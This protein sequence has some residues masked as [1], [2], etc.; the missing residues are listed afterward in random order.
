M[1]DPFLFQFDCLMDQKSAYISLECNCMLEDMR[2]DSIPFELIILLLIYTNVLK[3]K[4]EKTITK[5]WLWLKLL[6][7]N[8]LIGHANNTWHLFSDNKPNTNVEIS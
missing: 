5:L 8:V 4:E 1:D 3:G 2:L 7:A 6:E